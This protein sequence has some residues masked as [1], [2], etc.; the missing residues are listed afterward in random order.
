MLNLPLG[1][2]PP[3]RKGSFEEPEPVRGLC[4][5]RL[6]VTVSLSGSIATRL[7]LGDGNKRPKTF[8]PVD[9]PEGVF[10][11]EIDRCRSKS[12][13]DEPRAIAGDEGKDAEG[14]RELEGVCGGV[15]YAYA[16]CCCCCCCCVAPVCC[17]RGDTGGDSE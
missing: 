15:L 6:S 9:E 14:S 3:L 13:P 2:V 11:L 8:K 4:P 7:N 17:V 12:V 10:G 1:G 5:L 16:L